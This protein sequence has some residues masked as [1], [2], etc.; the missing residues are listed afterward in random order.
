MQTPGP[1][2]PRTVGGHGRRSPACHAAAGRLPAGHVC[3]RAVQCQPAETPGPVR[4]L[5]AG[6][7]GGPRSPAR[8]P[9]AGRLLAGDHRGRCGPARGQAPTRHAAAVRRFPGLLC[10]GARQGRPLGVPAEQAAGPTRAGFLP[11]GRATDPAAGGGPG[12][13]GRRSA[14]AGALRSP[15]DLH[16]GGRLGQRRCVP[17][18]RRRGECLEHVP[19]AARPAARGRRRRPGPREDAQ[20]VRPAELRNR[21]PHRP[22]ALRGR[23]RG[24]ARRGARL[25]PRRH[26]GQHVQAGGL[27]VHLPAARRARPT[28]LRAGALR[29]VRGAHGDP[30][31]GQALS[32]RGAPPE[33]RERRPHELLRARREGHRDRGGGRHDQRVRPDRP[34]PL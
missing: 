34:R 28:A 3:C 31:P 30:Q 7:H 15:E 10:R 1:A 26:V 29:R 13:C 19:L 9:A 11:R 24:A 14:A 23:G 22:G 21:Q 27:L 17:R 4:I 16:P 18:V 25:L 12:R 5:A 20:Q 8:H 32:A 6:G 2:R 33:P